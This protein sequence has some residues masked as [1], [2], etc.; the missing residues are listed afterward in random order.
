MGRVVVHENG[1]WV[2]E[3]DGKKIINKELIG[4]H[5]LYVVISDSLYLLAAADWFHR[6]KFDTVK[7]EGR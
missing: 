7:T 5:W 6:Q 1:R 3:S 2:H 4:S